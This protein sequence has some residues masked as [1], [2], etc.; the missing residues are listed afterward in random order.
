[1]ARP[2]NPTVVWR[3]DHYRFRCRFRGGGRPWIELPSG[4]TQRQA[5]EKALAIAKL[6]SSGQLEPSTPTGEKRTRTTRAAETVAAWSERWVEDRERRGLASAHDDRTR[7]A[8]YV[9]PIIG[10]RPVATVT[11]EHI[12]AVVVDLDK[13]VRAQAMHWKTAANVWGNVTK[14]FDD[15]AHAKDPSLR[16]RRDNP[17]KDLRGPDRGAKKVKAFLHPS[18]ARTL[19]ACALV[20]LDFRRACA[21][22]MYLGVRAGEL[23]V[24]RWDDIDLEHGT[25]HVHRAFDRDR[26]ITKP[27]KSMRARR[28]TFEPSVRP[29]LEAMHT[30][31][32]GRGLVPDM[33][34]F[35]KSADDLRAHLRTAGVSRADL[36]VNDQTRKHITFHDLR[37]TCLTWMAIRGD[38]PLRIKA[39]AGHSD[40][41]TTEGYVRTAEEI[42]G[43]VGEVFAAL[44]AGL[45][46]ECGPAIWSTSAPVAPK[47]STKPQR[48]RQESDL[49]PTL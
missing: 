13:R 27:T 48:P 15:A 6:A 33:R 41:Q 37:A 44:P 31:A 35:F 25:I 26:R 39:R 3:D 32:A 7:L 18:E 8:M 12:E 42:Q 14:L 29:L 28:F 10:Q 2:L 23:S 24:L 49:R 34:R 30:E 36:F 22:A 21:L 9:L 20:P 17:A 5:E 40:L 38:S 16:V 45:L 46:G 47:T 19:L 1:M 43:E 4:L 11:Q